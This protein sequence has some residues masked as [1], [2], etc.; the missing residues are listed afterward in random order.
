MVETRE[1]EKWD[2]VRVMERVGTWSG[3]LAWVSE[4]LKRVMIRG[5]QDLVNQ[6]M[7]SAATCTVEMKYLWFLGEM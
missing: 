2:E 3:N 7:E 5:A 6:C 4:G 1:V